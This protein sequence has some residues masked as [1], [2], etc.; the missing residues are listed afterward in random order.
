VRILSAS[1]EL[2][3]I[4]QTGGL[5]EAAAGLARALVRR[6]HEV[7]CAIPAS[8]AAL[9]WLQRPDAPRLGP[10]GSVRVALPGGDLHASWL[11]AELA[12][13]LS[14][15]LLDAPALF[16][17]PSL[18]G[19]PDDALRF[20]AFSRA[21]AYRAESLLPDLVLA[22]DWHAAFALC[23]LRTALDR[24]PN[25]AIGTVQAIHNNAYQGRFAPAAMA[26][27]GLPPELYHADGLEAWSTL[28]LLKG[29]IGWADRI[30]AVSP[31]YAQEIQT[32]LA[33]EGLEGFYRQRHHRLSGIA[34]GIEMERFDPANDPALPESFDAKRPEGKA[35][36]REA[37]LH[38]LDLVRPPPGR[39]LGA[40]GR[41]ALQKGWDVL[42]AALDDLVA[43]GAS[44]AL[45]GDGD[46][47]IAAMI[48]AA[49]ARHPGRVAVRLGYD[50]PLARRIYAGADAILIPSRFEPCGLVQ[51]IAQRYGALPV[52][53]RVGGLADTIVDPGEGRGDDGW[54]RGTGIL[55][56]PL[57]PEMLAA[58]AERVARLAESG[59]LEAAQRRLLRLDVSWTR[60][61][62]QWEK[63]LET[64]RR[65]ALGRL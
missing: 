53:H 57:S 35:K 52:A 4:V 8:R 63:L 59:Q 12:P 9:A 41:F 7:W 49:A 10:G 60:P 38:E 54:S 29:G 32:P 65:E 22:H 13:G 42:A 18:Y 20:V 43:Q 61:A 17:R 58:A 31:T 50:E 44:V 28:C 40:V 37:L 62:A 5:G 23:F 11:V 6:G 3:P 16:D 19:Q 34:N 64:A 33:G 45:L 55:F 27:T 21:L 26:L 2:A 30:V 36:C 14:L 46:P 48:L 24:G 25:R 51:R 56:S 1:A 47:P 39:L 15:H